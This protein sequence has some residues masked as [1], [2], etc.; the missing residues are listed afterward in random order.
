MVDLAVWFVSV[1]VVILATPLALALIVAATI[2]AFSLAGKVRRAA[3]WT[4]EAVI[5]SIADPLGR[6]AVAATEAALRLV[7]R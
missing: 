1:I 3:A 2:G 6:A 7:R 5:M 4:L